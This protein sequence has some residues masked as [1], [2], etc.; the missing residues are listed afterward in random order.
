MLETQLSARGTLISH[1]SPVCGTER[2]R[3]RLPVKHFLRP[4]GKLDGKS[5]TD[6]RSFW[7]YDNLGVHTVFMIVGSHIVLVICS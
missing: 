5:M 4:V 7:H 2:L 1:R 3:Y 6:L